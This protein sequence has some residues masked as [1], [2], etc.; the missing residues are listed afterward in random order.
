MKFQQRDIERY[1]FYFR[2]VLSKM[3]GLTLYV[4]SWEYKHKV[5]S[6]STPLKV[7]I[8]KFV[9]S[10]ICFDVVLNLSGFKYSFRC[11]KILVLVNVEIC[12]PLL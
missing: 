6:I 3:F 10:N 9:E 11:L 4:A 12:I 1:R 5:C 2:K 7:Q 8:E